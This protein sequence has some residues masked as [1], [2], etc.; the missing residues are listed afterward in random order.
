MRCSLGVGLVAAM[1]V[2]ADISF[3]SLLDEESWTHVEET[4]FSR[5]DTDYEPSIRDDISEMLPFVTDQD[6]VGISANYNTDVIV[7]SAWKSLPNREIELPWESGFWNKFLDPSISAYNML[8]RGIKRPMPFHAEPLQHETMEDVVDKPVV[9]K[10]TLPVTGF[11]QHIKDVPE[12][13]WREEREATWEIAIRRWIL[14]LEQWETRDVPLLEALHSKSSFVE[15]TQILVDVFYN[16]APQTLLKRVNSLAKLC[17]TLQAQGI[18]FPCA[19]EQFYFFLKHET[20]LKAPASRLKAFFE[21]IVFSRH[22]LGVE[23]LQA[24][25]TSRRCLGASSNFSLG[26]SKQAEPF[27]VM[28]LQRLHE[29]L[30]DGP[31]LWDQVMSGMILFCVYRRS[32]WS[33]SQHAECLIPDFDLEGKLQFLE[34][35]SAVHKTA[36]AFHLRHMFLPVAAPAYGVTQDCWGEQWMKARVALDISDLSV[37]PLMPAPDSCLEPTKRPISTSE[38]K[39]WILHLL[40]PELVRSDAK[41]TSHSCKCTC[42]SFLAK[43]GANFED[44]LVLGYHANKLRMAMTYSRDSAA[45]PLSILSQVLQEIRDGIFNPDN[46]RSGRLH[47]GAKPLDGNCTV[48]QAFSADASHD[49]TDDIVTV[50]QEDNLDKSGHVVAPQEPSDDP[51]AAELE[52]HVTTDSSS[53]SGE[54]F[55]NWPKV[56]GHYKVDIPGD[57]SMW[58]NSNTKMFHLSHVEHVKI[59]L[60]GRR[61][62]SSF[63]SHSEPIRFDAAKCRQC[64]RLKDS[65][66]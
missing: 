41:L 13:T 38:A 2:P 5:V 17:R 59:L 40:G 61:I 12:R 22:V 18:G 14:L 4:G 11:L 66:H 10:Q 45:R 6:D 20:E 32:R 37:F 50:E 25:V 8:A 63:K 51:E 48:G 26:C 15:R 47:P 43:R 53:S 36:R 58:L 3:D 56:I 21:S 28:Q 39:K 31:E 27:S 35:K 55:K 23:P 54:E 34:I 49:K 65:S 30:R 42:L 29:V 44:R 1:E 33:D 46:T 62:T 7:Q 16:K 19:E 57:K 60:C 9:T 24:I 52:G 64:F